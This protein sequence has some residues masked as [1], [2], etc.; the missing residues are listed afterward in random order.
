[1]LSL[2]LQVII[3]LFPGCDEINNLKIH[4]KHVSQGGEKVLGNCI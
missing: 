4:F 1:M 2:N 3:F